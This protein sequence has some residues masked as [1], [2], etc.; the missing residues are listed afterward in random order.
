MTV[1]LRSVVA[2]GAPPLVALCKIA[3]L[4]T[5]KN[6]L[7]CAGNAAKTNYHIKTYINI[8]LPQKTRQKTAI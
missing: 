8:H 4:T 5:H 1:G 3:D 6:T 2:L 7:F